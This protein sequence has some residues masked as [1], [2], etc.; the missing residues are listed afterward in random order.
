MFN[1]Q[2]RMK[3]NNLIV[4]S[5]S[6]FCNK[7]GIPTTFKIDKELDEKTYCMVKHVYLLAH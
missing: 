6:D 2:N 1:A 7:L 3:E 5:E 4:I